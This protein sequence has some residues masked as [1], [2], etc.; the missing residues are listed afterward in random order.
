MNLLQLVFATLFV[1]APPEDATTSVPRFDADL[2]T[3]ERTALREG[4]DRVFPLACTPTPCVGDCTEDQPSVSLAIGGA[5]RDY[6]LR[7]VAKAPHLEAPLIVESRCEL[8]SLAEVQEQFAADLGDLCARLNASVN[9]PGR[10]RVTAQPERAWVQIDGRRVGQ[11][12]WAHEL[13][14]GEHQLEVGARGYDNQ[15]RTLQVFAGVEQ[16][17]HVE[18][19]ALPRTHRPAWP[20]WSSLGVGIALSLAGTTLIAIDGRD[21]RGRCSG[22]NIDANGD[23]RFVYRTLPLGVAL[24]SLGAVSMASGVGLML[25]AHDGDRGAALAWR[26]SF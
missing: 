11:T 20:G 24:A 25:W 18:L 19:L 5:S 16:H 12:P 2:P 14:A 17:E 15:T 3:H 26:G 1:F 7:W 9:A 4:F 8:C 23:C 22:A 13:A 10:V 6:T 21:W